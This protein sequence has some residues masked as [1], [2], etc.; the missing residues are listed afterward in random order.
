MQQSDNGFLPETRPPTRG[1]QKEDQ[2]QQTMLQCFHQESF[3]AQDQFDGSQYYLQCTS[4]STNGAPFG[5]F[6]LVSLMEPLCQVPAVIPQFIMSLSTISI[7]T[8]NNIC[9][10]MMPFHEGNKTRARINVTTG[11]KTFSWLY[12]T[13]A[14]VTCMRV[15][16][17]QTKVY[18]KGTDLYGS[19][20]LKMDS[21]GMFELLMTIRGR[22]FLHWV[23]IMED[24][25]DNIIGINFMHAHNMNYDTSSEQITFAHMLT[26]ALYAI[27]ET[28]ITAL[29]SMT[30]NIK[31][32]GTVY[33]SAQPIATIHAPQNPTISGMLAW[34]MVEKYKNCKVVFDNCAPFDISIVRNE[35]LGVLEFEQEPCLPL[36][37]S[38]IASVIA[39]IH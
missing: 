18:Q 1:M 29:S 17:C 19:K 8:C 20:W 7:A 2:S 13:G 3:L 38:T 28:T 9:K 35:L 25:N 5:G 32:E 21:L 6:S 23:V 37:E 31:F 24:L 22:K 14:A 15:D 10:I 4:T 12:D 11:E 26:N 27:K 34:V 30:I 16:I 39:D 36:T 33:D